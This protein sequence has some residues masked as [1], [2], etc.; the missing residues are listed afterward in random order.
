MD[1]RP[2][3]LPFNASWVVEASRRLSWGEKAVW[4]KCH[5]LQGPEGDHLTAAQEAVRLGLTEETVQTYRQRLRKL[6]LLVSRPRPGAKKTRGWFAV[7]PLECIPRGRIDFPAGLIALASQLDA[8][9]VRADA[10]SDRTPTIGPEV[11]SVSDADNCP[12]APPPS[13]LGSGANAPTPSVFPL[14][15]GGTTELGVGAS[16]PEPN[17]EDAREVGSVSD[18]ARRDRAA[19]LQ[20]LGRGR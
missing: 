14:Q 4:L 1:E 16:A 2:A 18:A 9:I 12:V 3:K 7:L 5:A 15:V 6:G 10:L 11:G 13:K 20:R 17:M 8:A 19:R